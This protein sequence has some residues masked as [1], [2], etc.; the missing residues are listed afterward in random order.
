MGQSCCL[1]VQNAR[2]GEMADE[3]VYLTRCDLYTKEDL[4]EGVS[5]TFK[6]RLP[7]V[8]IRAETGLILNRAYRH[9][10]PFR[11]EHCCP[12]V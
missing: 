1:N 4:Q 11:G 5:T 9:V 3:A 12:A 6:A 10:T 8:L 2:L 7:C